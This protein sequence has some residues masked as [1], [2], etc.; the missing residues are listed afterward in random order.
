MKI[1]IQ[2]EAKELAA[3]VLELQKQP[4]E[5]IPEDS[6]YGKQIKKEKQSGM[7]KPN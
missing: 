6:K 7:V 3:L 4:I 5:F 1:I 2:A